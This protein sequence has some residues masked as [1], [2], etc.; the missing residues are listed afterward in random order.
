MDFALRLGKQVGAPL[1]VASAATQR[2]HEAIE[3]GEGDL[4]FSAVASQW[5]KKP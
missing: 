3:R 2:Y 1:H 5:N 4:D